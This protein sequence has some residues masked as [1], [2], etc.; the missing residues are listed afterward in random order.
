MLILDIV[1]RSGRSLLSA[2]TR[3]ILTAFAIA[4]GAF[5]LTLTLG[6]SNGAQQYANVIVK[7]NF[8]PS[9]LIVTNDNSLFS[10]TDSSK[11]QV[12]DQSFGSV[13]SASGVSKQVKMLTDADLSRLAQVKGVSSVRPAISLNLQYVTRDGQKKY[14]GTVEAYSAYKTPDV[15]AGNIPAKLLPHSVIL[16]QAFVAAL[17]FRS[18][19]DA[20]GKPIRLAVRR[21]YDQAGL[22]ASLLSGNVSAL[23]SQ[24]NSATNTTE[25]IFTI[26]AVIKPPATLIQPATALYLDISA[27]DVAR[28]NDYATLGTTSYH[29][30]LSAYVTVTDGTNVAKLNAV[31]ASIKK[32]G[33][34]A[35]SI[36]DTEKTITQVITVL[37]GIVT[38]F[39]LIA[40]VASVFGVVN[41]MYISV[42]QRTREIG[43]MKALG[44]HKKDIN[45]LFLFEAALIGMLGGVLGSVFGVALGTILNPVISRQLNLGSIKLLDF[46][47]SQI[48]LLV[49]ALVVVAIVAGLF[50]ARKASR[51]DPIDA[52]RTE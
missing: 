8:D 33:Y 49:L 4:V 10:T 26:I 14:V 50:P 51:L 29:K 28:L 16:P 23:S 22:L 15:L 52:L 6:A 2:K 44:M 39:G 38:V 45:K 27:S 12:Y 3:T 18:P 47:L 35:Q 11:P 19:Q 48:V 5:A 21:Q 1:R 34:S 32:L 9:E 42:L 46:K 13:T 17:G 31:Q 41:T 30:Y 43:L 40:I 24:Q 25:E 7:D 37:R 20:I 36:L